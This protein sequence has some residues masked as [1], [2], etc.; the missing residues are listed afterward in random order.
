VA[1]AQDFYETETMFFVSVKA[2]NTRYKVS[3]EL[4]WRVAIISLYHPSYLIFLNLKAFIK[5]L[6]YQ[7]GIS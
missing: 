5:Y 2:V 7:E 1:L 4:S 3:R 6:L